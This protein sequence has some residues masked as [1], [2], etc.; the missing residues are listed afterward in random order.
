MYRIDYYWHEMIADDRFRYAALPKRARAS[1]EPPVV[2][3][4]RKRVQ[5][6]LP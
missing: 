5:F 4:M 1:R 6:S 3:F 2:S